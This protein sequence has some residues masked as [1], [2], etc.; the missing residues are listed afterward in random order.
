MKLSIVLPVYNVQKYL[1]RCV[2]S[3]MEQIDGRHDL[4]L[5]LVDDGSKDNSCQMCDDYSKK[6]QNV[7]T[8]HQKNSGTGAARNTGIKNARGDYIYFADPDDYL[9]ADAVAEIL[10]LVEKK[11]NLVIFSYWDIDSLTGKKQKKF[12]DTTGFL[13]KTAFRDSFVALFKTEMLYTVW[14]KV[15]SRKFLTKNNLFFGDA[16]MGQDVRF[17]LAVYENVER[18]FLSDK[19]LY[20]YIQDRQGSSTNKYMKSRFQLKCEEITLLRGLL[21]LFKQNDFQFI[22]L[23]YHNVFLDAARQIAI[24]NFPLKDKRRELNKLRNTELFL[25]LED[26]RFK[27]SVSWSLLY[28]KKYSYLVLYIKLR[29]SME[30][31]AGLITR[32]LRT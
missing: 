20:Y 3:I 31:R 14:N 19:C 28:K 5:I 2:A 22:S 10:N 9:A 16:P 27:K 15:Y 17:N 12:F 6:Y 32:R 13:N 26:E 1:D 11:V 4:E 24:S 30:A 7:K 23:L 21:T 25:L 29:L 8:I 18:L